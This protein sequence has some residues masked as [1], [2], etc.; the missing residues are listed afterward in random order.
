MT[1]KDNGAGEAY[2]R[3]EGMSAPVVTHGNP[4][5]PPDPAEHNSGFPRL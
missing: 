5:L 1:L 2:Y 3:K 4:A